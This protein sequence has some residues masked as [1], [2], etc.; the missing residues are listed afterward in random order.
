MDIEPLGKDHIAGVR[1][2]YAAVINPAY[3]SYGEINEGIATPTKFLKNAEAVLKT[4]ILAHLSDRTECGFVALEEGRVVGFIHAYLER[5]KAKLKE[6][7]I[8]DMGVRDEVRGQ[9]IGTQ[10]LERV[11][12]WGEEHGVG[13]YA[14]RSGVNNVNAHHLFEKM[15][16]MPCDITFVKTANRKSFE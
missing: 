9:G 4:E 14:L 7:Y 6:C 16:F 2:C 12:S 13:Y 5:T 8:A 11:F 3:I 1:D 15:G 10:L